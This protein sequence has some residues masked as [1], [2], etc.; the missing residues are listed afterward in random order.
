[1]T[2]VDVASTMGQNDVTVPSDGYDAS[3]LNA[4]RHGILSRFTVLP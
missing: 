1:M 2:N 4:V 3:R